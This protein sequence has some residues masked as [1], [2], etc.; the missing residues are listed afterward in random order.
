MFQTY[1]KVERHSSNSGSISEELV[2]A[3]HKVDF[4]QVPGSVFAQEATTLTPKVTDSSLSKDYAHL[5]E[6]LW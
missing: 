5:W 6:F 3:S 4:F 1:K 2:V